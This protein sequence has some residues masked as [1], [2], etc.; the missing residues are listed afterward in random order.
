MSNEESALEKQIRAICPAGAVGYRLVGTSAGVGRYPRTA[1]HGRDYFIIT[2]E[3]VEFPLGAPKGSYQLQ[4]IENT[5]IAIPQRRQILVSVADTEQDAA[6]DDE[7]R[8][9]AAAAAEQGDAAS[10]AHYQAKAQEIE[11]RR[12]NLGL[13]RVARKTSEI[14]EYHAHWSS[15][16]DDTINRFQKLDE[17]SV[18]YHEVQ[19]KMTMRLHDELAKV[20]PPPPPPQ[21][22]AGLLKSGIEGIKDIAT[23]ALTASQRARPL[24]SSAMV[25]DFIGKLISRFTGTA[26]VPVPVPAAAPVPVPAAAPAPVPVAAPVPAP[27]PAPA[28][29]PIPAAA[30]VSPPATA[31]ASAPATAPIP[32]PAAAPAPTPAAAPA[33]KND[34]DPPPPAVPTEQS[35]PP[36]P[37]APTHAAYRAAW[38]G[39]KRLIVS[40][41]DM[42][43]IHMV[44]NPA[45]MVAVISTVAALAPHVPPQLPHG[46]TVQEERH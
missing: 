4:F 5:G 41:T 35:A 38:A 26:L 31:S 10:S 17:Y 11:L 44:V 39:M 7:G 18:K 32:T 13:A 24:E 30:P 6:S 8:D 2:P 16:F 46:A 23:T 43:I 12:R 14:S 34:Q 22:W 19:L 3:L 1:E 27:A 28:P 42:D 21:D 33:P 45:M 15:M 36:P 9:A 40:L 29:A 37:Q 25:D 20:P